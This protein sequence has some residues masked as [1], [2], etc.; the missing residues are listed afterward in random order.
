MSTVEEIEERRAKIVMDISAIDAQLG[1]TRRFDATLGRELDRAEYSQWR[2]RALSARGEK[3]KALLVANKELKAAR[4]AQQVKA[5]P[6][7]SPDGLLLS[8]Y[9]LLRR[10]AD[11]GVDLDPDEF[12]VMDAVRAHLQRVGKMA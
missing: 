8:A 3:V 2:N 6:D 9:T 10:L 7:S 12:A 1:Q 4:A 5:A 11:E